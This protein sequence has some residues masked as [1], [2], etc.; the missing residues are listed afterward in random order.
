M[1]DLLVVREL[2]GGMYFGQKNTGVLEDGQLRGG[3]NGLQHERDR[4]HRARRLQK[5]TAPPASDGID[6][7]NMLENGVLWRDVSRGWPPVSG[8]ALEHMFVD[9][10]AMQ[11]LLRPT[12]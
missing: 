9:N 7:A 10:A 5:C 6:K 12:G 3:Y 4:A 2:T 1:V 11:F 8:V